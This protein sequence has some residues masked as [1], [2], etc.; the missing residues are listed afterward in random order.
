MATQWGCEH[1]DIAR[2][3]YMSE[4]TRQGHDSLRF[5]PA[6]F[7]IMKTFHSLALHPMV[8]CPVTAVGMV[9]MK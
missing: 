8:L 1:K 5:S 3:Q 9:V 7:V 6:G 2:K 4:K